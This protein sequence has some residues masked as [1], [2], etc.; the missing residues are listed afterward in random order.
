MAT[1]VTERPNHT[2]T[3]TVE[4]NA[5]LSEARR[6][7]RPV[8]ETRREA[9]QLYEPLARYT[10]ARANRLDR[11]NRL[12][13]LAIRPS[14]GPPLTQGE[15]HDAILDAMYDE[16]GRLRLEPGVEPDA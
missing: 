10:P 5:K 15:A 16:A 2:L 3:P 4:R 8:P 7:K 12:G 9:Q 1:P 6:R 13:M 14:P 11:L